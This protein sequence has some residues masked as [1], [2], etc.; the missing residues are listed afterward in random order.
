[1]PARAAFNY[2]IGSQAVGQE[3]HQQFKSRFNSRRKHRKL[4]AFSNFLLPFSLRIVKGQK[5]QFYCYDKTPTTFRPTLAALLSRAAAEAEQKE[6][7][8][9]VDR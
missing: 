2:Y 7:A 9:Q 5:R 4:K 6:L 3:Q 1:M 8:V